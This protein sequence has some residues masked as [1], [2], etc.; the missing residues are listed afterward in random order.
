MNCKKIEEFLSAYID[1]Q[2]SPG[3]KKDVDLHLKGCLNCSKRLAD[4]KTVVGLV[5]SLEPKQL[6]QYYQTQLDA[7]LAESIRQDSRRFSLWT[8]FTWQMVFGVFFLGIFIGSGVLYVSQKTIKK[9]NE[10]IYS[11]RINEMGVLTFNL[12]SKENVKSI[13]FNVKLP[14]GISLA[15]KPKEK[16]FHWQG[17][18]VKG[19]NVISLYVKGMKPGNWSVNAHLQSDGTILKE[20]N[21]PLTVTEK[22]G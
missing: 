1:N 4:L 18:L 22:K 12:Y 7:K 2:L 11:I 20:F 9:P 3:L 13:V 21:M 5:S 16:T 8:S 6:P 14:D 17:E 15:S 10:A 19:E